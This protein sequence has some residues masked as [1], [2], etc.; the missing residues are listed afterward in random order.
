MTSIYLV[1]FP[2]TA[3]NPDR[4]NLPLPQLISYLIPEARV[5]NQDIFHSNVTSEPENRDAEG[6]ESESAEQ[7][8]GKGYD[9]K[10]RTQDVQGASQMVDNE[11]KAHRGQRPT[12]SIPEESTLA[13]SISMDITQN[14]N[15]VTGRKLRQR[16]R[17][18]HYLSP[19]WIEQEALSLL[20]T[21]KQD[22][23]HGKYDKGASIVLSGF[24]FGGIVGKRVMG[25]LGRFGN[26]LGEV[27]EWQDED[28]NSLAWCNVGDL[29]KLKALRTQ[30]APAHLLNSET[31]D[32][33]PSVSG[34]LDTLQAL[35]HSR[36]MLYE[37][38][39]LAKSESFTI[40]RK[41]LQPACQG[42][43]LE[44]IF[45]PITPSK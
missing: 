9:G 42:Y 2:C 12:L 25:K 21:I 26:E 27:I 32:H 18:I 1:G 43:T 35:S 38:R 3:V 7:S 15:T 37:I 29:P 14:Q 22:V 23:T 24:G 13:P 11:E 17:I 28:F 10:R 16:D 41:V 39:N 40:L 8:C 20:R 31:I 34:Y 5:S 33:S 36:W 44:K 6:F 30:F 4:E 19:A 45:A